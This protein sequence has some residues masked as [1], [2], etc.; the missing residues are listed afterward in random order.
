M[1]TVTGH[2]TSVPAAT[3]AWQAL[4]RARSHAAS[5]GKNGASIITRTILA[6]TAVPAAS[7]PICRPA[8]TTCA[9]SCT[10]EPR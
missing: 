4:A 5:I 2:S 3:D 7:G 6:I 9:T 1:G 10:V 8:A